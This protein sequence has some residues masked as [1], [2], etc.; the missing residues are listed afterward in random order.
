M[1]D[2]RTRW[3]LRA[4]ADTSGRVWPS[5]DVELV[6][7]TAADVVVEAIERAA[8]A[9]GIHLERVPPARRGRPPKVD[10]PTPSRSTSPETVAGSTEQDTP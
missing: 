5:L 4:I 1:S 2:L 3:R 7:D 9:N 6:V 8:R 10:E